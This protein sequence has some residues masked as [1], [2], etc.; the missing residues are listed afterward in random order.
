LKQI[1][2]HNEVQMWKII[3]NTK[4]ILIWIIQFFVHIDIIYKNSFKKLDVFFCF[5]EPQPWMNLHM[6][7]LII[8]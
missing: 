6:M 7:H 4:M 3:T 5:L 8:V 2:M 1:L